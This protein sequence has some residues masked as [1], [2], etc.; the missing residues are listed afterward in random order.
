MHGLPVTKMQDL[1][2]L[3]SCPKIQ[4]ALNCCLPQLCTFR[5]DLV[6]Q[7]IP[8]IFGDASTG[9]KGQSRDIVHNPTLAKAVLLLVSQSR[10]NEPK[11][12]TV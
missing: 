9:Q 12:G 3:Y 1:A 4:Y 7:W 11:I 8:K 2:H 6:K 5:I 10:K